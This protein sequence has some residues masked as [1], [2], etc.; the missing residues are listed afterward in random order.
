MKSYYK[1]IFF[2]LALLWMVLIFTLSDQPRAES[3][4][5]S[6]NLTEKVMSTIKKVSPQLE[7]SEVRLHHLI[8]KSAHFFAYCFLGI[9]VCFAIKRM[10]LTQARGIGLAL[11]ICILFAISDETHQL[12]VSGRGAEIKDVVIDSAG[13]SLGIVLY[14]CMANLVKRFSKDV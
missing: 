12:F 10:K 11:T 8:R 7:V 4:V 6:L 9:L 2:L 1:Y 5:L 14:L 13:A 3:R